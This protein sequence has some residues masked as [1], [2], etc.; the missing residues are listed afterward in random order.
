MKDLL[1]FA[2]VNNEE[3][4]SLRPAGTSLYQK[5][6]LAF[7]S[8]HTP[9]SRLFGDPIIGEVAHECVSEG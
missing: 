2:E 3:L 1:W 7:P 9:N 6:A 5:E 8:I 4:R